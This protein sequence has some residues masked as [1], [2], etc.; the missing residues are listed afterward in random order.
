MV[1]TPAEW[2]W[3]HLLPHVM[4]VAAYCDTMKHGSELAALVRI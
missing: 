1:P 3:R 2:A 4:P